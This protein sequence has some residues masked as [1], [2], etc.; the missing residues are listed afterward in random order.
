MTLAVGTRVLIRESFERILG[1]GTLQRGVTRHPGVEALV[2]EVG[3]IK[4]SPTGIQSYLVEILP[5]KG[6]LASCQSPMFWVDASQFVVIDAP[7]ELVD[8]TLERVRNRIEEMGVTPLDIER[9][10]EQE[11][12]AV[13]KRVLHTLNSIAQVLP[14]QE[15][16][17]TVKLS[18]PKGHGHW[19]VAY[20]NDA[21]KDFFGPTPEGN[22]DGRFVSVEPK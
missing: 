8:G 6:E 5:P 9:M 4:E 16:E 20:I 15:Y 17:F 18:L 21:M 14:Q 11:V 2:K 10:S 1:D 19:G 7:K 22:E 12:R 3:D 13:A